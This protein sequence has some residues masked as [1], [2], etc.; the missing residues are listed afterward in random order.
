MT[1]SDAYIFT[2]FVMYVPDE[3][4][5]LEVPN[6]KTNTKEQ[7][8]MCTVT[9]ADQSGPILV[10][11]WRQGAQ[12]AL[13]DLKTWDESTEEAVLVRM[14]RFHIRPL[15][16]RDCP[17]VPLANKLV[18]NDRTTLM[19]ALVSDLNTTLVSN[20][21]IEPELYIED[22][23]ALAIVPPFRTSVAGCVVEVQT[24]T[25]S[26]GGVAMREFK[27]IDRGGHYVHCTCFGRQVDNEYLTEKNRVAVFFATG[28]AGLSNS[29][30]QLF[31]YDET[32]VSF[33]ST[34]TTAPPGITLTD[35]RAA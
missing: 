2:G 19:R 25:V 24:E 33:L 32:H 28:R 15:A 6:K 18:G 9:L 11:F 12:N 21:H 20:P 7:V 16:R 4:R 23:S 13:R 22:F 31:L 35:F 8:A 10:D 34:L 30:G 27:L 5:W 3:V 1:N 17:S 14:N 29:P 26:E